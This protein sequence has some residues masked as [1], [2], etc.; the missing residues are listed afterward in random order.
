MK[1]IL[2]PIAAL[3]L[4][5]SCNPSS[6]DSYQT[7]PFAESNLIVDTQDDSELAQ[8]SDAVYSLKQNISQ[9]TVE[10]STSNL[11]VNN[12]TQSFETEAMAINQDVYQF[13]EDGKEQTGYKWTFKKDGNA[14]ANG[15]VTNLKGS[16][17]TCYYT[18]TAV[19]NP[20]Y[21]IKYFTR[22][23]LSYTLHGRYKVQTFWPTALYKG[24]TI[25]TD[26]AES[27]SSKTADYISVI[28]FTK[29][30]GSVYIYNAE[31]SADT[32]KALPKVIA[33]EDIPVV[34]THDGFSLQSAAPKT[35]VLGKN[36]NKTE[37]IESEEYAAT[38]FSLVLTSSDLT[39]AA[40]SFKLDG[41]FVKFS[42]SS[43]LKLGF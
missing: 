14:S 29:K 30:V 21:I 15:S 11:S 25:A 31:F 19:D 28:D 1:K 20:N 3:A 37:L 33:I 23:D 2:F 43:T 10:L 9:N 27:F 40:I 12:M 36:D 41:K 4:L 13:I 7:V 18:D 35:R 34:F 26:D 39:D 24:T 6:K 5:A 42:G 16:L 17:I 22:M 32:E 38:D 8:V